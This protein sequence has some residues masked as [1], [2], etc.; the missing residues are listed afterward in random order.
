MK[1]D[2]DNNKLT[3]VNLMSS[4]SFHL[5]TTKLIKKVEDSLIVGCLGQITTLAIPW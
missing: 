5:V 3:I 4:Y 2:Y 1:T